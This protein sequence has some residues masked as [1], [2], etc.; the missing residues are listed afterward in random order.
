MH[1]FLLVIP[2]PTHLLSPIHPPSIHTHTHT[3]IHTQTHIIKSITTIKQLFSEW[4]TNTV[5]EIQL[6]VQ[7]PLCTVFQCQVGEGRLGIGLAFELSQGLLF[8]LPSR[9]ENYAKTM[10]TV[11]VKSPAYTCWNLSPS[12]SPHPPPPLPSL[13][14]FIKC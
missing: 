4:G 1:K 7:S 8:K 11:T 14:L 6:M 3:H 12:T 13:H 9:G 5:C 10:V 2:L